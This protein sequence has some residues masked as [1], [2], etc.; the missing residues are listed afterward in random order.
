MLLTIHFLHPAF[1]YALSG[2]AIPIILHLF[3]LKKYKKVYFSNFNFLESLQQQKKNSSRLKN[4]LLLL[5]RL[6][7]ITAIVFAFAAPY[8]TPKNKRDTETHRPEIVVYV[9]NSFSMSNTGT[10]G[11]LLEEAKKHLFD[12]VSNYPV[13]TTFTLLTNDNVNNTNLTKEQTINS[14]SSIKPT[15]ALKPLSQIFREARNLSALSPVSLF[16]ISDFQKYACDFQSITP[17]SLTQPIFLML[18][19][20]NR[21]NIYIKEVEFEQAFHQKNQNDKIKIRVVNSSDKDF[22]N[23]PISL[24]I[25]DKKKS[26]NKINIPANQEEIVEISYLNSNDDFHKGIVEISDFP[27]VFDN[28]FY[29]SYGVNESIRILCLEQ[30]NHIPHFGKL[31]TDSASFQIDYANI[32]QTANIN[33][34]NYN[35][36][37]L[38]RIRN[39]TTGLESALENYVTEGGNLFILPGEQTSANVLNKLL[40]K[41]HAPQFEAR[42]TNTVIT[43][44]EAQSA[45]F[46]DVFEKQDESIVLPGAKH[47]YRLRLADKSEI[48]LKDKRDNTLLSAQNFGRGNVYISAFDFAPENSNM[49]YH[50]LFVPLMVNM[51]YNINSS[52]QTFHFLHAD[53]PVRIN[54]R[55]FADHL[56]TLVRN[57]DRSFEFIP[58]IRKD[59]SGNTIFTNTADITADGIYDILQDN[60]IIDVLAWNYNRNESQLLFCDEKELRQHFPQANIENIRTTQLDRN[61]EVVKEIVLQDNNKYLGFWFLL[62]GI[63]ALLAE[64]FV[65]RKKLM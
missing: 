9:D 54:S 55:R 47:F 1:L 41:M 64:Q 34:R 61:S 4:I 63:V 14:L 36:I 43:Y 29:F 30:D 18:N 65:W 44:I 23:I 22:N 32:N 56:Q 16:I 13:G 27:V 24:T 42:D 20:E 25:N 33:F 10:K 8:I 49:V 50:P 51:A 48:L 35:L 5:L 31:F 2:L 60:Q 11:T 17:D 7:A 15:P 58:D 59:V 52:L 46:K 37:I 19:P 39:S 3:S 26:T 21:N 40:Q 38:D 28:K 45:L 6:L 53:A 12:I 62:L 57:N